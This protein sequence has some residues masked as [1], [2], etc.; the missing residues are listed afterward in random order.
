MGA[1][2][3]TPADA[4]AEAA[5]YAGPPPVRTTTAG[6]A[7]LTATVTAIEGTVIRVRV[8]DAEGVISLAD[9]GLDVLSSR[10]LAGQEVPVFALPERRHGLPSFSTQGLLRAADREPPGSERPTRPARN[11]VRE[12]V[13]TEIEG[14]QIYVNAGGESG[15]AAYADV[16]LDQLA[17]GVTVG[18]T[19]R[20]RRVAGTRRGLSVFSVRGL[21][22]NLWTRLPAVY[23]VGDVVRGRVCRI[24]PGFV[25]V[26]VLPGVTLLAPIGELEWGFIQHPS[27]V[28]HVGQRVKA[29]ILSLDPE[30]RRGT[31]SIK[32]AYPSDA[33]P[34]VSPGPG[35]PL[36]L[37]DEPGGPAAGRGEDPAAQILAELESAHAGHA[38]LMRRL[39][40]TSDQA[41]DLRRELRSAEDRRRAFEQ[42]ASGD[43]DPTASEPAFLTA[44]RVE[45]ARR[46][47]ED[48]RLRYPLQRMR[49]GRE[50]LERLR[51]LDGISVEKVIEVCVQVACQRAHEVPAREVHQLRSGDAGAPARVRARDN[52]KAWRCSL[53]DNTA[54]ARRLHWWDIPGERGRTIEF[55]SVAV[56]DDM[57]IPD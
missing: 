48:D 14:D 34:P 50:F 37:A 57:S 18:Q 54:S 32:Q 49:V 31:V 33:L 11:E 53:Q 28:L 42:R 24:D 1:P 21:A 10:L 25:L 22:P 9:E 8:G 41:S 5:R 15:I 55:A 35:Q 13:V 6:L 4:I 3:A 40:I 47:D 51:D 23:R 20:V 45:Y 39:K 29:K 26:E 12:A 56:H 27:E 16:P 19:L 52:A 44:V 30:R 7:V 43:L 46:F 38:E 36:F 2:G 17:A